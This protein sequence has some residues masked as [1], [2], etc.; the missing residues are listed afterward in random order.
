M[1]IA[2]V[3]NFQYNCGSS[4]ALL[5]Y[6]L[7]GKE[8]GIDVRV[9]EFG[10]TDETIQ[11][12]I[13]VANRSWKP[14]M[15]VVVYESYPF[16]SNEDIEAIQK[17]IPRR[18]VVIIDPDGKYLPIINA[19]GDTNHDTQESYMYWKGIY[20]SL[21]DTILQPTLTEPV[22]DNVHSFLY[23]GMHKLF[24]NEKD[25][26]KDFDLL[27]VGNNWYRWH[28]ILWLVNGISSH[29]DVIKRVGLVGQFWNGEVMEGYENATYSDTDFLASNEI[30]MLNSA[31]YGQVEKTMGKG[32]IHPILVR[33]ILNKMEFAT[34]RMLETFVADTVPVIPDY[35]MHANKL[36]GEEVE[37]L[38]LGKY[39][40]EKIASIISNYNYYKNKAH[41]IKQHLISKHSYEQRLIELVQY[42]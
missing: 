13:S 28:D 3:G 2:F 6:Y 20:D 25:D 41:L 39:P 36:Y 1:K 29:R 17:S 11:K 10:Y 26:R 35:F 16:L 4:N 8:L 33:P 19:N 18:N 23:F 22:V 38:T 27:Y 30:E 21:S 37:S 7:A 40:G 14:D 12:K 5:G 32:R 15:L 31:P 34:P 9:S 24:L 42:V